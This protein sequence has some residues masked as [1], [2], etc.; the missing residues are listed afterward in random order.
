M[1]IFTNKLF[2]SLKL[3]KNIKLSNELFN[4][5]KLSL[6]IEKKNHTVP[7][8]VFLTVAR[9][10]VRSLSQKLCIKWV[11]NEIYITDLGS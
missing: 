1:V 9:R 11:A 7:F 3:F 4:P 2:Y 6:S 5:H 8:T 10:S